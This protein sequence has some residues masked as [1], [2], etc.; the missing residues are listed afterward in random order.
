M[1]SRFDCFAKNFRQQF[2]QTHKRSS[3]HEDSSERIQNYNDI[4]LQNA[5]VNENF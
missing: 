1:N 5:I 4:S 3:R 2:Q